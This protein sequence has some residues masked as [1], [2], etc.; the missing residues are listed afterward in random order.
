MDAEGIADVRSARMKRALSLVVL[1]AWNLAFAYACGGS[2]TTQQP[3]EQ[4][5]SA[6]ETASEELCK[7]ACQCSAGVGCN[8]RDVE[9]GVTTKTPSME[10]CK[11]LLIDGECKGSSN[12]GVDYEACELAVK[13]AQ[14]IVDDKGVNAVSR[15]R[16]CTVPVDKP[17]A[18]DAGDTG[19]KG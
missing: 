13:G 6:C 4:Q 7:R 5:K 16:V 8:F 18:G 19:T 15:P 10:Q 9:V 1:A 2:D 3:F 14:C 12:P 17:D 11:A